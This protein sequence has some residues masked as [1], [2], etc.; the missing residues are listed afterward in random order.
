MSGKTDAFRLHADWLMSDAACVSAIVNGP[1]NWGSATPQPSSLLT[2]PVAGSSRT[3]HS[4]TTTGIDLF[5]LDPT[6]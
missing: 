3:E 5:H 1:L 6:K 2:R 4:R